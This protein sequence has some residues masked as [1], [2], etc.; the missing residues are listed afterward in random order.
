MP[1]FCQSLLF[2][3]LLWTGPVSVSLFS[4]SSKQEPWVPQVQPGLS[5][6]ELLLP[7]L[8]V[9]PGGSESKETAHHAGALVPSLGQEDPLEKEMAT[10]SS[11]LAWRIPWAKEP[12][13]IYSP[14]LL[15]VI[16]V[17]WIR[18]A[19]LS[20]SRALTKI[21]FLFYPAFLV[22]WMITWKG[23]RRFR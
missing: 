17:P 14:Y 3:S 4:A 7:H 1:V 5:G 2:I 15:F 12:G 9:S 16:Q 20:C 11:I 23:F 6:Q 22:I 21:L 18:V 10:Y 8:L 13:G 19:S